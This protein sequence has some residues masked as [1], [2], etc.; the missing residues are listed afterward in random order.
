MT[1]SLRIIQ[2]VAEDDLII[3]IN[4]SE[5]KQIQRQY[6]RPRAACRNF[7]REIGS[8][9]NQHYFSKEKK[10]EVKELS[11]Q[12]ISFLFFFIKIQSDN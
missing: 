10:P 9:E 7:E 5:K 1:Q 6:V 3:H 11:Y 4:R 2:E 8:S 12:E